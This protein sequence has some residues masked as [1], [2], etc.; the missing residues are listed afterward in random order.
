MQDCYAKFYGSVIT[1]LGAARVSLSAKLITFMERI[2]GKNAQFIETRKMKGKCSY[3]VFPIGNYS[4]TIV[5][6][7][8]DNI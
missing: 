5:Y 7:M 1:C 8:D 3:G 2:H 4:L 6:Q